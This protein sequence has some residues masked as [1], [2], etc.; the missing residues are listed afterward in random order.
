MIQTAIGE[1]RQ[2]RSASWDVKSKVH[3]LSSLR[4]NCA[5]VLTTVALRWTWKRKRCT[6]EKQVATVFLFGEGALGSLLI[7]SLCIYIRST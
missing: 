6:A 1:S 3:V 5:V 7:S 2:R 4:S